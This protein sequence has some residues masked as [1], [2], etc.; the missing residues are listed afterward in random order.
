MIKLTRGLE[1]DFLIHNKTEL[2]NSLKEA[3]M[4]YGSYKLI[5]PDAK[6]KLVCH[7]RHSE[8]KAALIESSYG[9]CAFCEC[10]PSEGGNVEVEHFKPKSKH[11][12]STFEW[13]NLLPAC[14]RCNGS[15]DDHDTESEPIVNPYIQDPSDFFFYESLN[16]KPLTGANYKIASRTIEVCGLNTI[17]LWKPRSQILVSLHDFEQSLEAALEDFREADTMRKKANRKR[18]IREAVSRIEELSKTA[19]KYSA[20]CGF[21]LRDSEIYREA[22]LLI[23]S[24]AL[25]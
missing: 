12:N 1:P 17:R 25:N 24:D 20:F 10:V 16:I 9:K 21:F 22:R 4:I 13:E 18:S 6:E 2:W 19:E 7:Y 8:I 23:E 15:K 14:R 11:P 3:I 5:P